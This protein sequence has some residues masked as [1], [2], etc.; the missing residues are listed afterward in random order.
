M[1]RNIGVKISLASGHLP[2]T[3]EI[4]R[5]I[6]SKYKSNKTKIGAYHKVSFYSTTNMQARN[7]AT[8]KKLKNLKN[9]K[10]HSKI[11]RMNLLSE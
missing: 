7:K 4:T 2:P 3:I 10:N 6:L 11:G 9:Q 1:E 8:K 5:K